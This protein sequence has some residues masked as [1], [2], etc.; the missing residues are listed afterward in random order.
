M[1]SSAS[2]VFV[3]ALAPHCSGFKWPRQLAG[4][5]RSPRN[6]E[7]PV[8]SLRVQA[9]SFAG[10]ANHGPD[11]RFRSGQRAQSPRGLAGR[12]LAILSL[13]QLYAVCPV[14]PS[15]WAIR[16]SRLPASITSRI[17]RSSTGSL[18]GR[19]PPHH[20]RDST[21]PPRANARTIPDQTVGRFRSRLT[22]SDLLQIVT[23]CVFASLV[24][25]IDILAGHVVA[26]KGE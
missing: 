24:G 21:T 23:E 1:N 15:C 13:R 9:V 19:C 11:L 17:L 8:R 16:G 18:L 2:L 5:S 22:P 7:R 25:T 6:A 3:A 20:P 12:C 10:S 14:F 4:R 26:A